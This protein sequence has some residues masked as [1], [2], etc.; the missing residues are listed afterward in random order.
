MD[1]RT[2]TLRRCWSAPFTRLLIGQTPGCLNESE[3]TGALCWVCTRGVN[4]VNMHRMIGK[5]RPR[6][7]TCVH[8]HG[9]VVMIDAWR[10]MSCSLV[11]RMHEHL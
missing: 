5:N 1:T 3:A 11:E 8:C 7:G 9:N 2:Q 10:V 4:Q 6:Q